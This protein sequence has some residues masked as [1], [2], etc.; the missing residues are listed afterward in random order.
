VPVGDALLTGRSEGPYMKLLVLGATGPTGRLVVERALE[1]GDEVTV[2]ARR[3]EA[4]D[5]LAGR[6]TV[7]AGDATSSA[8]VAKAMAGQEVVISALGRGRSIR[9]E[10]FFTNAATAVVDAA[11]QTG[12]SRLVWMTSFGVGETFKDANAL[13][14]VM[15]RTFLKNIYTNKE[16][17][18]RTIRSSGLEWTLVYPSA[19]SN[20]PAKGAYTVGDHVE[21]KMAARIS[22]ADVADFMVK[23]ARSPEWIHRNAVIT[24]R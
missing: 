15:Y 22:R 6:V 13:Q 18:E 20:G 4:L 2:L 5:A 1:S 8:E 16:L 12:V 24:D 7:V 10:D 19:L 17:S 9:A 21:M 14:R 23:A 3:P 11:K